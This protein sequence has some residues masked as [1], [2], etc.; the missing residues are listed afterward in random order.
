MPIRGFVHPLPQAIDRSWPAESWCDSHVLLAVSGGADSTALLRAILEIKRQSGGLGAVHVAHLNHGLRGESADADQ[1]WVAELCRRRRVKLWC[2]RLVVPRSNAPEGWEAAARDA[3]YEFLT[4][5]AEQIGARY[6][7]TAHTA[8]DQVETVLHR[9]LRGTGVDGL[10][11]I[12]ARRPLSP[13]VLLVRPMLHITRDQVLDYLMALGQEFRTD[14]TNNSSEFTRNWIRRELLPSI[15]KRLN[16]DVD[17]ALLRLAQQA[18]EMREA[19]TKKVDRL[20]E[21]AVLL[22]KCETLEVNIQLGSLAN[23]SPFLVREVCKRAWQLAGFPLRDMGYDQWQQ[24]AGMVL[25]G[26]RTAVMLPG[27][28][29]A[30]ANDRVL[31]LRNPR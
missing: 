5:T 9:I 23:E 10:T 13:A 11:G 17:Q 8:D 1:N 7:V 22:V 30:E 15:R 29:R 12:P 24:L 25:A 28:V 3:R 4:N 19:I 21:E 6:V 26:N 18:G 20:F 14:E 2:E 31:S 16:P 27:G